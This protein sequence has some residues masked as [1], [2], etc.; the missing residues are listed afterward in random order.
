MRGRGGIGKVG[1]GHDRSIPASGVVRSCQRLLRGPHCLPKEPEGS[2]TV[3]NTSPL[4]SQQ[5]DGRVPLSSVGAAAKA[6]S[7]GSCS[8][9]VLPAAARRT[10]RTMLRRLSAAGSG[11][12]APELDSPKRLP[13]RSA[14]SSWE[15][16]L[17]WL[18]AL[19]VR[20]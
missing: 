19:E 20:S 18:G 12:I 17:V 9:S 16:R 10:K 5:A 15:T 3:A 14:L 4:G 2:G 1:V 13:R 11:T 8:S 6:P 7:V